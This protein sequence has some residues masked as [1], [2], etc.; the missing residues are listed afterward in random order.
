MWSFRHLAGRAENKMG[1][2]EYIAFSTLWGCVVFASYAW[3]IRDKAE[4]FKVM[5]ET[6][7]VAT[8]SLFLLGTLFG[9]VGYC[10]LWCFLW[11]L[12]KWGK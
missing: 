9:L 1:D 10:V 12:R 6:P 4:L 8:P 3:L 5:Q 11:L 7:F 2:F